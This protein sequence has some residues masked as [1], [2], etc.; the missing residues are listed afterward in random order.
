MH[1][2]LPWHRI[3]AHRETRQF[4][5]A[6]SVWCA[7]P[8]RPHLGKGSALRA[9]S[10]GSIEAAETEQKLGRLGGGLRLRA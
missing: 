4:P 5:L 6:A 8:G 9:I 10:A 1:E 7:R 2:M 3:G